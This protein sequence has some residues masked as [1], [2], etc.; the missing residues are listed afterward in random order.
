MHRARQLCSTPPASFPS[1]VRC[2]PIECVDR[3][4]VGALATPIVSITSALFP[5][6]TGVNT[7]I[8]IFG[9][10][11]S[12]SRNSPQ[13]LCFQTLPHS[14]TTLKMLSPVFSVRSALFAQKHRGVG[15]TSF[16]LKG[17]NP[18]R[19]SVVSSSSYVHPASPA[20]PARS[21]REQ[22]RT[23][24]RNLQLPARGKNENC[25]SFDFQ[26]STVNH[27]LPVSTEHGS[28]ATDHGL[29]RHAHPASLLLH[30]FLHNPPAQG[31]HP[32]S[33]HRSGRT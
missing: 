25:S 18:L 23:E 10:S 2:R 20:C 32:H 26:L 22:R 16:K 8:S 15:G 6:A 4:P 7:I 33:N 5:V 11:D 27:P 17:F 13:L 28:R 14:F 21:R 3:P 30:V 29:L 12:C 24:R 19:P 31:Q 9:R 1:A